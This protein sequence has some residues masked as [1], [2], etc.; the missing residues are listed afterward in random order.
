MAISKEFKILSEMPDNTQTLAIRLCVTDRIMATNAQAALALGLITYSTRDADGKPIEHKADEDAVKD[1]K[2]HCA[3]WWQNNCYVPQYYRLISE[4]DGTIE[5]CDKEAPNASYVSVEY[6]YNLGKS[7]LG[8]LKGHRDTPLTIKW[9]V[10]KVQKE[11]R[12]YADTRYQRLVEAAKK[13]L[14][15][16]DTAG[17]TRAPARELPV[18]LVDEMNKIEKRLKPQM[19]GGTAQFKILRETFIQGVLALLNARPESK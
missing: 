9:L 11:A 2:K 19:V 18:F 5:L 8:A 4:A 3:A 15:E 1:L 17:N 12:G 16:N 6:A 7:E 10:C 13:L 14:A